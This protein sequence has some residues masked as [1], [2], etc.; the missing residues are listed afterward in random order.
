MRWRESDDAPLRAALE[1]KLPGAQ[2]EFDRS[3]GRS[4]YVLVTAE[5]FSDMSQADQ[6]SL[7]WGVAMDAVGTYRASQLDFIFT[8]RP[9]Q[10]TPA[11]S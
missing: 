8:Y 2:I 10:R 4:V 9:E 11:A 6:Q 1:A 7:V 5:Q 3:D